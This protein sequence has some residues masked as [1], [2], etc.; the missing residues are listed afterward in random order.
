MQQK[1]VNEHRDHELRKYKKNIVT[2]FNEQ[3][4]IRKRVIVEVQEH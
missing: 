4:A 2:Q 1:L 3:I